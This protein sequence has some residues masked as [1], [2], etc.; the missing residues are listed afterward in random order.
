M[1]LPP[2]RLLAGSAVAGLLFLLPVGAPANAQDNRNTGDWVQTGGV[3]LSFIAAVGGATA[4]SAIL[5]RRLS[6]SGAEGKRDDDKLN[7]VLARFDQLDS[8]I[9][10]LNKK[11][12]KSE[13]E[14]QELNS[15]LKSK[16]NLEREVDTISTSVETVKQHIIKVKGIVER[17]MEE[18]EDAQTEQS[19]FNSDETIENCNSQ[20]RSIIIDISDIINGSIVHLLEVDSFEELKGPII[21]HQCVLN[22]LDGLANDNKDINKRRQGVAGWKNL[23]ELRAKYQDRIDDIRYDPGERQKPDEKL[24]QIT[25]DNNGI[26][27]TRDR[28]L[29]QK[30]CEQSLR[31]I[32][33]DDL[34]KALRKENLV[35]REFEVD[36]KRQSKRDSQEHPEDAVAYVYESR[37]IVKNASEY[38]DHRKSIVINGVSR[39][40]TYFAEVID[41]EPPTV[42][43]ENPPQTPPAP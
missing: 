9:K 31:T 5:W 35:G 26:L 4:V 33:V 10:M 6:K 32:N 17:A 42:T 7:A 3:V 14:T 19:L 34:S 36:L 22:E 20:L 39:G 29:A 24:L 25:K 23:S 21:I 37:V 27:F 2:R 13:E 41:A 15:M 28:E 40:G 16:M 12:I 1:P 11:L 30:C 38:I 43:P 18:K 8:S